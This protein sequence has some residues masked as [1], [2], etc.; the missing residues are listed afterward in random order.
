M[1]RKQLINTILEIFNNHIQSYVTISVNG[2]KQKITEYT[3][4][5][6]YPFD[7]FDKTMLVI[8]LENEFHVFFDDVNFF[9][10]NSRVCK[11]ADVIESK[12][13]GNG[14]PRRL[15]RITKDARTLAEAIYE[16]NNKEGLYEETYVNRNLKNIEE[17]IK[18]IENWLKE[19]VD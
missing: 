12:L 17:E 16:R 11:I 1:E 9:K 10:E 2:K 19:E 6:D 8:K 4:L 14:K 13:N 7:N 15:D 3:D 5:H 18:S